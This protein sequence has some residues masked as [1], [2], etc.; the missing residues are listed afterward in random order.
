MAG[1]KNPGPLGTDTNR[2]TID[3]GTSVRAQS[4]PPR[5]VGAT[6]SA[7]PVSP[8][9]AKLNRI[10]DWFG[11]LGSG[12]QMGTWWL[13][14]SP[15]LGMGDGG[16]EFGPGDRET[17]YIRNTG[18]YQEAVEIYQEWLNSGQPAGKFEIKGTRC[19]F[20]ASK[21]YFFVQGRTG[22]TGPRAKFTEPLEH[23]VWG[24]TGNFGIRFTE[25]GYPS[26]GYVSVEIENYTSIP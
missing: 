12:I 10:G 5:P 16:W 20:V 1:S 18:A 8:L 23:P 11:E 25:T 21:G 3:R 26:E 15:S 6:I 2:P 13:I 22:G 17:E 7:A 9:K 24:F 14:G 19:E 4:N